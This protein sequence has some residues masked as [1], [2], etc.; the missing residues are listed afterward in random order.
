MVV[1]VRLQATVELLLHTVG[2]NCSSHLALSRTV[3]PLWG[4]TPQQCHEF[5][6]PR[7]HCASFNR[8]VTGKTK[9]IITKSVNA[10][11]IKKKTTTRKDVNVEGAETVVVVARVHVCGYDEREEELH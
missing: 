10:N 1:S 6:L 9:K 8:D 5:R 4:R 2:R 11:I 3:F 7:C